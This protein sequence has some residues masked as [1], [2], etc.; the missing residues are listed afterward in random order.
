M[1]ENENDFIEYE[2]PAPKVA[3][4]VLNRPKQANAQDT[5]LL[6]ELNDAFDR[7][8][9]DDE[10]NV[11]ILAAN[12]K[13]FSAGHD[14]AERDQPEHIAK[15]RT[16]GTTCGFACSGAEGQMAREQELYLGFSERWR[17]ID[18][19]TI[20]AVQGKCIAAGLMLA[21]PCDLIIASDDAVFCDPTVSFG[22]PGHEF[23]THVYE[24]GMRKAK[25]L[26]F[27]SDTWTAQEALAFGMI[28]RIV[29]RDA[30][31]HSTLEIATKIAAKPRFALKLV[32]KALNGAADAHG[33][34][35]AMSNAFHLH[36]L[37]H[38]HN[39]K[40]F[41]MALDPT[42]LPEE[43]RRAMAKRTA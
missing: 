39:F 1:A 17:N 4:I 26:L 41:G 35:S 34:T 25:E 11:I 24:M 33:R 12:G 8:A 2:Q 20:A 23:F 37:A 19:P 29:S 38:A 13:N 28:N 10:I 36:Q 7:A 3:R 27:T 14:L 40:E 21:W 16:V 5:R 42:A 31:S 32:K 30:L 18:K 6:Y 9:H 15:F 22:I 43:T